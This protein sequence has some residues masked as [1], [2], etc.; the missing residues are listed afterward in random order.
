MKKCIF[1]M[2]S[3]LLFFSCKEENETEEKVAEVQVEKVTI[4]R[5]DKLFFESKPEDLARLKQQFPFLFPS[6]NTDAV[7]QARMND[8]F[9]RKLYEEVQKKYPSL[10]SLDSDMEN[11]FRHIKYYYPNFKTP[12]VITI[13]NDDNSL[14]S[15]Y[16]DNLVIIPLSLYL[17]KDNYLYEGLPKYQV[18]EYEPSQVVPDVVAAFTMGRIPAP[19]DNTL[20]GEMIYHG[21]EL[22]LKDMLIPDDADAHKIGYTKEQMEWSRINE[23]EIWRYFVDRK[24]LYAT[25][26][27]LFDR[28]I[29]P[30]PFSKFY[31]ELDNESPGRIGQWIGWQI[32]RSYAENNKNV[33]LQQLLAMDAKALFDKSKYKPKNDVE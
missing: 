8:P 15:V 21:K 2:A 28:F 23:A 17:G 1:L 20:L 11:L 19:K 9:L 33:P 25:D 5:F 29:K 26:H 16:Q 6:G 24:L 14:K 10:Q 27:K 32:V 3:L 13:V 4:E 18:Q 30:A 7:W 12:R 31:L 22:Y